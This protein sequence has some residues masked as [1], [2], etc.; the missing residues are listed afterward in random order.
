MA[1]IFNIIK[2][3]SQK[4][5]SITIPLNRLL[6]KAEKGLIKEDILI[7]VQLPCQVSY[8]KISALQTDLNE[9]DVIL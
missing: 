6:E 7:G 5:S 2:A 8:K 9:Q 1:C 3:Y 4:D